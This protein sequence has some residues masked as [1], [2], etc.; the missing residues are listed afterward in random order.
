MNNRVSNWIQRAKQSKLQVHNFIEGDHQKCVGSEVIS[1]YSPRDG[2]LIYKFAQGDGSEVDNAVRSARDA[3]EDGR[4][5]TL[6]VSTRK[7]VIH[8]LANLVE[9]NKEAL[10]L[11]DSIDVGKPISNA[12]VDDIS[13]TTTS[14][15]DAADNIDK[16][17]SPSGSEGPNLSYRLRKPVGVVAGI[18]SWNYPLAIAASKIGPALI[19]GNS[20]VLKP[21]EYSPLSAGL[22]AELAIEAGVPPGVFN[23]VNGA[24]ITVGK[25]LASHNDVDLLSFT[26]GSST[27]KHLMTAAGLSNMKRLILECGGKSPYIVFNDHPGDIDYIATDVV[28]TAFPNQ[29]ALC[30][31]GTRLLVEEGIKDQLLQAIIEK[32]KKIEPGD[33]LDPKTTFGALINEAH[34]KKVLSYIDSGKREGANLLCGGRQVHAGTGGYYV[35][36]AV[37]DHVGIDYGIATEEIFGPVLSVFSFKDEEEAIQIANSTD[38]GLAAYVA[39][40]NLSKIQR[41]SQGLDSG[42]VVVLS[43]DKPCGGFA[44]IGIEGHKQSGFGYEGGLDGLAAYTISSAIHLIA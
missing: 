24:G 10:A 33:P 31:A 38:F 39:T 13:R 30:V 9:A 23:I 20:I 14:L 15:R 26:G 29:G 11:Y 3:F 40:E 2:S 36:P 44:P 17:L 43:T 22:L 28:S 18:T 27:G 25:S 5:R 8:K 37:F 1:K 16:L 6:S 41:I 7:T 35:E 32:T 4:W 12:L 19:T 34:M 42:L 21:S